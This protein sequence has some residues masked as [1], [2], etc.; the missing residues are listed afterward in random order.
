MFEVKVE[1]HSRRMA[2]ASNSTPERRR[3]SSSSIFNEQIVK[4]SGNIGL[5]CWLKSYQMNTTR[6]A[7]YTARF[8]DSRKNRLMSGFNGEDSGNAYFVSLD[9]KTDESSAQEAA[10]AE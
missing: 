1:G 9:G 3:L 8:N 2:K 4:F 10:A 5:R 7:V 6:C